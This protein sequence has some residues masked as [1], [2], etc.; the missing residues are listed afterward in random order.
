MVYL[1]F[2]EEDVEE[3]LL[4]KYRAKL[5]DFPHCKLS[6]STCWWEVRED[7]WLDVASWVHGG[8]DYA[9]AVFTTTT[10][11]VNLLANFGPTA[12]SFMDVTMA[13]SKAMAVAHTCNFKEL[14]RTE[15][16][17]QQ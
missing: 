8:R 16:T 6:W 7:S 13:P 4:R 9:Y 5:T 14:F 2:H 1:E 17:G 10:T 12:E 3:Y 11:A 15:Y